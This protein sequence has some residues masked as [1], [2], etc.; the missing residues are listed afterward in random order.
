MRHLVVFKAALC[1]LPVALFVAGS[2]YAVPV[3]GSLEFF[4][5]GG[6]INTDTNMIVGGVAPVYNATGDL[7]SLNG[8]I[9]TL[10]SFNYDAFSGATPLWTAN[11][12]SD[13]FNPVT[14]YTAIAT[15]I[16]SVSEESLGYAD[17]VILSGTGAM[18]VTGFDTTQMY[19]ELVA[20]DLADAVLYINFTSEND[21]GGGGA[22]GTPMPEPGAFLTFGLG[23]VIVR[24]SLK[25]K[26]R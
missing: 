7:S 13:P 25:R 22:G 4:V 16:T 5:S 21:T 20:T 6:F 2:A 3:S 26:S 19:F 9:I 24:G 12:Y 1:A 17:E 11:D 15:E 18:I 14:T 8:Q 23:L 10:N